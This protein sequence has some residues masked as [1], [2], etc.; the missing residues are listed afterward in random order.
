MLL[1]NVF[2]IR[3][4]K[5]ELDATLTLYFRH[6]FICYVEGSKQIDF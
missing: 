3:L 6:P 5:I 2:L 1:L 4:F